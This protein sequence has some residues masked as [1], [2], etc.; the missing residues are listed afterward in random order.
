MPLIL[1]E[2]K[3]R[4]DPYGNENSSAYTTVTNF[5][6]SNGLARFT[7]STYMNEQAH[8]KGARPLLTKEYSSFVPHNK[9]LASAA[10]QLEKYAEEYALSLEEGD[11][12]DPAI[13]Q[14]PWEDWKR[15]T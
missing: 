15:A 11:P 13:T 7:L 8:Q 9:T 6:I 12:I 2:G 5:S 3:V 4:L 14:H 10:S 1:K